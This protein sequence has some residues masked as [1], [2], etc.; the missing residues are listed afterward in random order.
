MRFS[1]LIAAMFCYLAMVSGCA[2]TRAP[3]EARV[4][5]GLAGLE[6]E[7]REAKEDRR[8]ILQEMGEL[9]ARI[10]GLRMDV[11]NI[12]LEVGTMS[13]PAVGPEGLGS[14]ENADLHD[15]GPNPR[16]DD[17]APCPKK[18]PVDPAAGPGGGETYQKGLDLLEKG[19]PLAA[20]KTLETFAKNYPNTPLQ[21]NVLYW[22]GETYYSQQRFDRAILAFKKVPEKY[23]KD[24][25][26]P[27]ALFKIIACYVRLGDRQNAGFYMGILTNEYPGTRAVGL[28]EK[29][30]PGL[31]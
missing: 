12:A 9:S 7:Q 27:D 16:T 14:M 13:A 11:A 26:A 3:F 18:K 8:R 31:R 15:A 4:T 20:R 28:A 5:D 2:N 10:D 22:I 19:K 25:K 6:E 17:P 21:P 29:R 30:F 1:Y 23:P 24:D